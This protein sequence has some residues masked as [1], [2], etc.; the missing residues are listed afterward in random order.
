MD[1]K[2]NILI[3]L[4]ALSTESSCHYHRMS[5][6]ALKAMFEKFTGCYISEKQ[7]IKAMYAVGYNRKQVGSS[8][9]YKMEVKPLSIFAPYFWG[10]GYESKYF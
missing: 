7:F 4:I 10:H 1:N 2:T 8:Y 6:Y 9:L 5:S 3:I